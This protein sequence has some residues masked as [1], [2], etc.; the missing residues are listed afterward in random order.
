MT[1]VDQDKILLK[2]FLEKKIN[3]KVK[4]ILWLIAHINNVTQFAGDENKLK[5]LFFKRNVTD[6]A[7][8]YFYSTKGRLIDIL[9]NELGETRLEKRLIPFHLTQ[10][11]LASELMERLK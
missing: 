9:N 2:D 11:S 1:K 3:V 7:H 4:D 6:I 5:E 10:E 8:K